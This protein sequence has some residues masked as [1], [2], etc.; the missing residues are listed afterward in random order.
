MT[1][2]HKIVVGLEEI[3]AIVFEC[4]C[5]AKIVVSPD[6]A[7]KVPNTCPLGHSWSWDILDERMDP[8]S[9]FLALLRAV[10]KLRTPPLRDTAGFRI[11]FEFDDSSS[12][13]AQSRP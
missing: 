2:E 9:P 1:F 7:T 11:L 13:A 5:K 8:Q 10:K 6:D 12:F 4:K 3:R